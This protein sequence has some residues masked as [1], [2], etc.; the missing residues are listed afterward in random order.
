MSTFFLPGEKAFKCPVDDP[1]QME[2]TWTQFCKDAIPERPF[3]FWEWFFAIMKLTREQLRLLWKDNLIMGFVNKKVAEN[4]LIN[5]TPG[6]FLLRFSDS[7]LGGITIAWAGIVDGKPGVLMVSPFF[8]SNFK[9]R[10]L[11]DCIQDLKQLVTLY[12]NIPKDTAFGKYYTPRLRGLS[13]LRVIYVRFSYV[14]HFPL[15]KLN[16]GGYVPIE[17]KTTVPGNEPQPSVSPTEVTPFYMQ[18][19]QSSSTLAAQQQAYA[20]FE[21]C[22]Q[23]LK[24][25]IFTKFFNLRSL[26]KFPKFMCIK[27]TNI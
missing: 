8:A 26:L 17:L 3:T 1:S 16:P 9:I 12:P 18:P 23:I 24:C 19:G 7:G 22:Y 11:A 4:M 10:S 20:R 21:I 27:L 5:C 13:K 2:I 14:Y 6:T 15:D 25:F